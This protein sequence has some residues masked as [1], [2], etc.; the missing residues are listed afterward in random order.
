[1]DGDHCSVHGCGTG[2]PAAIVRVYKVVERCI[3]E[4]GA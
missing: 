2:E 3:C 4:V 1:M